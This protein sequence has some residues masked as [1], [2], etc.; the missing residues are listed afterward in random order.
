VSVGSV[1]ECQL[2]VVEKL[3]V[4]ANLLQKLLNKKERKVCTQLLGPT[5]FTAS[6]P[7]LWP[8]FTGL[9]TS[10]DSQI[11]SLFCNI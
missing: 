7:V 11:M 1:Q 3:E 5:F 8:S 6:L 10:V 2:S 9:R 4:I